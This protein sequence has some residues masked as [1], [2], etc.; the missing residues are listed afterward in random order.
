MLWVTDAEYL[1]G[2]RLRLSFNDGLSGEVDLAHRLRGDVF[3]PLKDVNL[4]GQVRFEP[5]MDT[6]VWPNGANLAPE[7]L[8]DQIVQQG[9]YVARQPISANSEDDILRVT[10]AKY[11]GEY[12]VWLQFSDGTSGEADLSAAMWGPVFQPLRDKAYFS[13]VK[14][15]PEMDTIVWPNGADLAPEYLKDLVSQQSAVSAKAS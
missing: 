14:F 5:D 12:R 8:H 11:V 9:S 10:G 4:F 13:Q 1:G 2:Y 3:E 6:I 7:Y 15:A